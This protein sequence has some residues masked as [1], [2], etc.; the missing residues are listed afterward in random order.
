MLMFESVA[1]VPDIIIDEPLTPNLIMDFNYSSRLSSKDTATPEAFNTLAQALP[2]VSLGSKYQ[3]NTQ[4]QTTQPEF[5]TDFGEMVSRLVGSTDGAGEAWPGTCQLPRPNM[6]TLHAIME[7]QMVQLPVKIEPDCPISHGNKSKKTTK[8]TKVNHVKPTGAISKVEK[9]RV[10][11]AIAAAPVRRSGTAGKESKPIKLTIEQIEKA[12]IL[13]PDHKPARG[14]G[15]QLQLKQMTQDQIKA[16]ALARLAK[17]RDAARG[18][19]QK[20]KELVTELEKKVSQLEAERAA[21]KAKIA[22]LEAMVSR[23][24]DMLGGKVPMY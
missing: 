17:N 1:T 22:N 3:D 19:R 12:G 4:T 21:D 8:S 16:E 15:R 24:S 5:P 6:Q 14:R 7:Q 23:M 20:R 13:P 2:D 9:Q 10:R 11:K 18:S